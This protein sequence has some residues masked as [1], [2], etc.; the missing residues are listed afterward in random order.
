MSP[1]MVLN[2]ENDHALGWEDFSTVGITYA[3]DGFWYILF[4]SV[5]EGIVIYYIWLPKLDYLQKKQ[6]CAKLQH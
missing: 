4:T 6:H 5:D 2:R 3:K 1:D